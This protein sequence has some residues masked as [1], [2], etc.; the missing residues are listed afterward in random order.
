M[1]KEQV[2]MGFIWGL[3]IDNQAMGVMDLPKKVNSVNSVKK[4]QNCLTGKARSS[5]ESTASKQMRGYALQESTLFKTS[6]RAIYERFTDNWS[7]N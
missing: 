5:C 3:L 6:L 2:R 7:N 1:I 4:F